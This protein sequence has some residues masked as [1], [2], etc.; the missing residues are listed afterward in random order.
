MERDLSAKDQEVNHLKSN[1][2]GLTC[3]LIARD[4]RNEQLHNDLNTLQSE[5]D[6]KLKE[7]DGIRNKYQIAMEENRK[8]MEK[9]SV[10]SDIFSE[11]SI[12]DSL[13]Y[14]PK[15]WNSYAYICTC[16]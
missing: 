4:Q 11:Y 12:P 7:I 5:Y 1:V 14:D 16:T 2:D 9:E 15:V 6:K 10:D 8:L 13:E 3:D